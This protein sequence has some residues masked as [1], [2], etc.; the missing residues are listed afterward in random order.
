[1]GIAKNISHDTFPRQ[2]DLVGRRTDVC[3]LYD[4]SHVISGTIVR[5]DREEPFVTII[6]LD[7][8]RYVLATECMYSPDYPPK[9]H[10]NET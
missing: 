8:G 7:D 6:R 10:G 1:M 5:D 9:E 3:F 2:G 4:T